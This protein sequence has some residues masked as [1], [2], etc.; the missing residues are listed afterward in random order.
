[1]IKKIALIKPPATYAS[2]YKKPVLGI[3][4]IAAYLEENGF[5]CKIFDAYFNNLTE[6]ILARNVV[7]YNPDIIGISSMTHEI[8]Q[9]ASIASI[10]KEKLN[11]PVVIGGCHVTALPER[12]LDEFPVFDYGIYGEGEQTMLELL[13]C[14]SGSSQQNLKSVRGL[15]F[16]EEKSIIVNEPRAFFTSSQLD[17]LPLPALHHYY[18]NNTEALKDKDA[19]YVMMSGRGCPYNC[20]FCMQVLGR[21]IRSRSPEN[22]CREIEHAVS[23]YGG[24]MISFIDE[25]FLNNDKRTEKVLQLMIE[26]GLS[27]KIKWAA[28]TRANI[29]NPELIDLAKRAG[30]FSISIGVESGDDE[31]L[32]AVGKGITVERIKKAVKIIKGAGLAL[33]TF[34]IIGHPNETK[35]TVRKTIDLAAELNPTT[36]AVGI[37]VPYPGTRVYNMAKNG[38]GGYRLLSENWAEYDKYGGRSLEVKTLTYEEME[39]YQMLAYVN[40][41]LKNLRMIDLLKFFYSKRK[42]F[43]FLINKIK[44][45]IFPSKR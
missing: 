27:K 25:L 19:Y 31:I 41:Y 43:F 36:I 10:L 24:H 13:D 21:K 12:T 9:A 32:K 18:D 5:D 3:S 39:R 45:N 14:L 26:T 29:V 6:D 20:A 7:G 4:Y 23:H 37:M 1:M 28:H 44:G 35:E 33:E 42:A 8:T 2:W 38:E 40:L 15:V 16:R 22:I 34:F 30:C 17:E 11:V